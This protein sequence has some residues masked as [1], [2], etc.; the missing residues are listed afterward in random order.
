M[1]NLQQYIL[2]ATRRAEYNRRFGKQNIPEVDRDGKVNRNDYNDYIEY[3]TQRKFRLDGVSADDANRFQQTINMITGKTPIIEKLRNAET[4]FNYISAL[5]SVTLLVRAPVASIA[6]PFTTAI[7][8]QSVTKGL[9]AFILTLQELPGISKLGGNKEDIR[10]RQQFARVL[11]IIDDPEVGDILSNRI[12]GSFVNNPKL[13]R[14]T[15]KFFYKT[16][17]TGM[18]NAQRRSAARIGFQFISEMAYEYKNPTSERSK[19][20]AKK[21][22]NDFGVSDKRMDQFADYMI[23]FNDFTK[24][25]FRKKSKIQGQT[26]LPNVDAIMND[27][28]EYTDMGLQL[29]VAIMRFTDQTIQDPRIADRPAWA[30]NPLGRIVYGIMSFIYSF[31]DKVLKGMARKVGREFQ[32]SKELKASTPKATLDASAYVLASIAPAATTLFIGHFLVSTIREVVFN[33]ERFEREWE[34]NDKDVD[35]FLTDFL[36]PLAFARSGFTGAFDPIVQTFTSLKYRRDLANFF[37]GTG[38]YVSENLARVAGVLRNNSP[39]TLASEYNFLLGLWNLT[40]NPALSVLYA[41]APLSPP[42]T[43]FGA[44]GLMY[45]TSEDFKRERINELLEL[46]YGER[47]VRGKRGRPSKKYKTPND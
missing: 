45:L 38:S 28:G 23:S 21:T 34:E 25:K 22:L 36:L 20:R 16:K 19:L 39:N 27:A 10:L 37:I 31:Q 6:E 17:L 46:I 13:Q 9:K 41:I 33:R 7:T 15:Q 32:I 11:G 40:L 3:L 35:K 8:S 18:T 5:V 44:P 12:G 42:T 14:L 47:Y 2:G 29:S 43:L 1:L 30:E 4:P 26:N 24:T